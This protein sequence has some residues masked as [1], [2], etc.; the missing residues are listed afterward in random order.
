MGLMVAPREDLFWI[1]PETR[2]WQQ[3]G[4]VHIRNDDLPA[5]GDLDVNR[6]VSEESV[7]LPTRRWRDGGI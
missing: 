6:G 7:P 1:E 2:A 4:C 3:G 5:G